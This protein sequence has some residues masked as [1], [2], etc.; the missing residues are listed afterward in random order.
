MI[1]NENRGSYG[2]F[3]RA[4]R[5]STEKFHILIKKDEILKGLSKRPK[6]K[7]EEV[8][9][10]SDIDI[11]EKEDEEGFFNSKLKFNT[12]KSKSNE[13]PQILKKMDN[14]FSEIIEKNKRANITPAFNK[15]NPKKDYV[16]KK[17]VSDYDFEK[18]KKKNFTI[19]PKEEIKAKY[20]IE[21]DVE[22]KNIQGKNFI[23]ISKQTK[24]GNFIGLKS[25]ITDDESSFKRNSTYDKTFTSGF[26]L[27]GKTQTSFRPNSLNRDI[28]ENYMRSSHTNFGMNSDIKR[29]TANSYKNNVFKTSYSSFPNYNKSKEDKKWIKI[30]AP[31]FKR[32]GLRSI[33]V[34]E[35]QNKEKK[36]IIPV[37]FPS[38]NGIKQSKIF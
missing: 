29:E 18:S 2:M 25:E 16:W 3:S 34:K 21:H 5:S 24:R 23:E 38:Y 13:K 10:E 9:E 27:K 36:R 33:L 37:R 12:N 28:D 8:S 15:Y 1:I 4:G 22:G 32:M 19:K 30:Q 31:D 20:Y 7:A 26:N 6:E 17:L 11:Y 35:D 14:K